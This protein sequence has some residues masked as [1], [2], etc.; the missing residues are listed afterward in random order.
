[1]LSANTKID[2]MQTIQL[3]DKQPFIFRFTINGIKAD[4]H[5]RPIAM[6]A[7]GLFPLKVKVK[8]STLGWHIKGKWVSYNQIRM[9]LKQAR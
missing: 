2:A 4:L 5:T 3:I 9:A 8:G 6:Y 1:M 7:N